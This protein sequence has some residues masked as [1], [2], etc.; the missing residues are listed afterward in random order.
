[1][2]RDVLLLDFGGVI[3]KTL[4]ECLDET[5]RQFGLA[6]GSLAWRGPLDPAADPLWRAMLAD[7]ISERDYWRRRTTEIAAMVGRELEVKDVVGATRGDDP[8]KAVRPEAIAT[9]RKVKEAGC[10]VGILSNELELFY[11]RETMSRLAVLEDIDCLVDNSWS[12]V[13]KP[14]P[15]A[16]E[17]ALR[18]MGVDAA[19]AVFVDDQP[20]NVAGARRVGI[21]AVAFDVRDPQ[22]SFR[23]AE[24]LLEID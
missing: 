17:R 1:M 4:F 22:G 20:R 24:R 9:I 18:E 8:N 21:A 3:S 7:E 5:E 6:A 15:E 19:R 13:L 23:A 14:A 16:Y 2:R 12:D 10:R 11:G